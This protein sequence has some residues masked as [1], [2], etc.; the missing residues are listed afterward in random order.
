MKKNKQK[1]KI[2]NVS[3]ITTAILDFNFLRIMKNNTV[4]ITSRH[5]SAVSTNTFPSKVE[6]CCNILHNGTALYRSTR[7]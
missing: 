2:D 1:K 6:M 3:N 5:A 7:T 4:I